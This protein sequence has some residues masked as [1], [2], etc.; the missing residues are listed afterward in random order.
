M[1][2]LRFVRWRIVEFCGWWIWV[3]RRSTSIQILSK[4]SLAMFGTYA[5]APS[6][7][8]DL[9]IISITLMTSRHLEN[10]LSFFGILFAATYTALTRRRNSMLEYLLEIRN[11]VVF[12]TIRV[13]LQNHTTSLENHTTIWAR[14]EIVNCVN[15]RIFCECSKFFFIQGLPRMICG[16]V[17]IAFGFFLLGIVLLFFVFVVSS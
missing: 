7:A 12:W 5:E 17:C 4:S 2:R 1:H 3:H 15:C 13:L 10:P 9:C 6:I 14:F 8:T 11:A 16:C